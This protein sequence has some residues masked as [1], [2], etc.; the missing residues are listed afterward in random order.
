M[1]TWLENQ[2]FSVI[3]VPENRLFVT[4]SG[5]T[6]QV[7]HAFNVNI[8]LYHLNGQL[9]RAPSQDPTIPMPLASDV[10]AITGLDGRSP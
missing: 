3:D 2:G 8:N 1:R 10:R 9:V 5:T 7:E 6:A 4:A